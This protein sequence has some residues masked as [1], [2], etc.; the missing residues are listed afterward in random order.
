MTFLDELYVN[1]D[2][3]RIAPRACRAPVPPAYCVADGHSF[4]MRRG[5]LLEIAFDLEQAGFATVHA[6][7]YYVPAPTRSR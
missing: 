7:G 1:H 4:V 6:R 2:G 3:E 5:D